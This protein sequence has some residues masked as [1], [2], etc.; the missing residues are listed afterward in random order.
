VATSG[1]RLV[2][3]G[4]L[5]PGDEPSVL[6]LAHQGE[7]VGELQIG[8]RR[9]E[10]SLAPS[11]LTVLEDLA[12]HVGAAV[13]AVAIVRDLTRARTRLVAAR[14]DERWRLQRD[15][16][17]G[18]G[19]A[20]TA[21][22]YTI[23]AA[24]NHLDTD[25]DD[26]RAL[27]GQAASQT[28][29]TIDDVRRIVYALGDPALDELSLVDAV[30]VQ[31]ER[32]EGDTGDCPAFVLETRNVV[33]LPSQVE[34]AAFRIVS[35]AMTNVVRH[36]RAGICRVSLAL[37]DGSLHIEVT[38]DGRGIPESTSRG[39]GM[40]SMRERAEALGGRFGVEAA[41]DG[42]TIVT[43]DLPTDAAVVIRD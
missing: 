42:G 39:V 9:G 27:L 13:Q 34:V 5:E 2:T 21:V 26:A 36:A 23:Q 7:I 14:D 25:V 35:E 43:V 31:A 22:L 30:R 3:R 28:R 4:A 41:H 10:T 16:H 15:L 19:P 40:T 37:D 29:Q 38:D 8:H 24:G 12:H 32:L 18:L 11:D 20:L 6:L 33:P 17:D 1:E